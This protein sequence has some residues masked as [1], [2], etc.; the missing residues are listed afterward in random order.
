MPESKATIDDLLNIMTQLRDPDSGCPWDIEQDFS[1]IAPYTIEEAYEVVEAIEHNDMPHLKEE[2][3][4]LLLQ[5]V[6][7]ARMAEEAKHFDFSDVVHSICAKM[8]RRHPHVF[9]DEQHR[10]AREQTIAW[11]Q[12]K[13]QER[14]AKDHTAS[15]LDGVTPALPALTRA[16]KLQN[17]AARV[18]FDWPDTAQVLD[19][20]NEEMAE[21][22]HELVEAD[23][24]N[25]RTTE[26]EE[27]FGDM[28][29]VYA[30]L[31]RHLNLDPE[32]AL[33]AANHKFERRFRQ[34][35]ILALAENTSL[36]NLSLDDMDQLWNAVKKSEK[37][38]KNL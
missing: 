1:S 25:D 20:L 7:H 34:V 27:E 24:G 3:G 29:F 26:I 28:M 17:R 23:K 9:G 21:L 11:E 36:E 6:F 14:K 38:G 18:G 15:V 13:A 35:E 8:T 32:K 2:L 31:A 4:D 22:S 5:V 30:N 33:R 10:N 16:I 12:Q 19:K 37:A